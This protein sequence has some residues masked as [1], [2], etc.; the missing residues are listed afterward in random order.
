MSRTFSFFIR[1]SEI[2]GILAQVV[3]KYDLWIAIVPDRPGDR[4]W[5]T[6][7]ETKFSALRKN[8]VE[9]IYLSPHR[10]DETIDYSTLFAPA[11]L[12]WIQFDLPIEDGKRLYLANIGIKSDWFDEGQSK[13][14]R[15]RE[16]ERL[17]ERVRHFLKKK[18]S[19]P[20]WGRNVK[21]EGSGACLSGLAY[22][23]AAKNWELQGG[24]LRQLAVENV[25]FSTEEM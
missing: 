6:N 21:I 8:G 3:G 18:L 15:N 12:G 23:E 2:P 7:D 25:L 5:V 13:I 19:T 4:I 20:V 22:S 17:F 10:P 11:Q 14:V 1:E 9:R 16:L 24:E